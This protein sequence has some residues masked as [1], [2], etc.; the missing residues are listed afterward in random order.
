VKIHLI[1]HG[2]TLANEQM[3]YCGQTDLPLLDSGAEE[4][5]QLTMQGIYPL[6]ELF[7]TSGLLR[8]EQTFDIIYQNAPKIAIPDMMEYN[9]GAFEMKSHEELNELDDYQAWITDNSGDFEC[10][11]GESKNQFESRVIAG[12]NGILNKSLNGDTKSIVTVCH[13]GTISCIMEHLCPNVQNF[14]EW[15]PGSG[16]GYTLIYMDG[17]FHTYKKI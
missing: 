1:R 2:R 7:F 12:Y 9:F 11:N 13:G 3:L 4:I 15:H 8:A 16:R 6:A 10:P 14:Y 5:L 17:K